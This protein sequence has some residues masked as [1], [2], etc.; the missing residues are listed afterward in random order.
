MDGQLR[1]GET[2]MTDFDRL[3]R[4]VHDE[5]AGTGPPEASVDSEFERELE[6]VLRDSDLSDASIEWLVSQAA[7]FEL[8]PESAASNVARAISVA[9]ASRPEL[10]SRREDVGMTVAD[11]ADLL[12]GLDTEALGALEADPGLRWTQLRPESVAAY[13]DRVGLSRSA[14]VR[15]LATRL[16]HGPQAAYGYRPGGAVVDRPVEVDEAEADVSRFYAWSRALLHAREPETGPAKD[17]RTR[18]GYAWSRS[19]LE[20][21]RTAVLQEAREY[22][23]RQP[24]FRS[25]PMVEWQGLVA[26][27]GSTAESEEG[28]LA[29]PTPEGRVYPR[30]QFDEPQRRLRPIVAELNR[31]L[32]VADDPWGVAGWWFNP[33]ARLGTRPADLV[34][35][36]SNDERLR[37]AVRDIE[38]FEG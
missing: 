22:I 19:G 18:F 9:G 13:L 6:S 23:L 5:L 2:S 10:A 31:R 34:A 35:D 11:A 1:E 38:D 36:T 28:V 15:W 4:E 33:N 16:P 24:L 32:G 7:G 17:L 25:N 37:E 14:F 20:S 29:L 12:G 30:F 8:R 3:R 27:R 26:L 21:R